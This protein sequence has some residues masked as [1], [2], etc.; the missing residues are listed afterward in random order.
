MFDAFNPKIILGVAAH[1]DD[2]E[3]TSGGI[4]S[5]FI[6][7]GAKVYYVV[8][9]DGSKGHLDH[10]FP[11]NKL[12]Q[13]RQ[14]E[15]LDAAKILGV[16]GITFLDYIDGE[17]ENTLE[18]RKQIVKAI[19]Q[20]KPDTVITFDPS[21]VYDE[22]NGMVNHPDHR[23]AGQATLDAV[24]PFARNSRTFPELIE[25]E[26]L[27]CHSVKDILLVNFSKANF[28]IDIEDEFST[29]LDAIKTHE[30]QYD[31]FDTVSQRVK[32]RAGEYGKRG[33]CKLAEGFVRITISS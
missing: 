32:K 33:D 31:D 10:K 19:R 5:K 29:K 28:F 6:K 15:Q 27:E 12:I 9:T 7:K 16:S 18:V 20:I 21:F 13:L 4:L 26:N 22:H 1:P 3:F 23:A 25:E 30:S 14:K 2:L 11:T 17:L 8:L 24:F